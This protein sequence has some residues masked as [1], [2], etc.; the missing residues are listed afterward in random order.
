[1]APSPRNWISIPGIGM[2]GD[3]WRANSTVGRALRLS[4]LNIGQTWPAVNDM[5]SDRPA[6]GVHILYVRGGRSQKPVGALSREPGLQAGGQHGDRGDIRQS[7][8]FRRRRRRAMDCAGNSRHGR[9]PKSSARSSGFTRRH[10]YWCFTQTALT[11]WVSWA[12]RA[13]ACR[14]GC[15]STRRFRTRR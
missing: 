12:T 13:R 14:N 11:N 15:T 2:L 9:R 10:I 3:G 1:M 6:R 4:L 7:A 5:A 8:R